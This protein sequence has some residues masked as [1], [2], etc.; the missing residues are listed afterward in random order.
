[1]YLYYF[2][3]PTGVKIIVKIFVFVSL[4]LAKLPRDDYTGP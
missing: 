1:M 3:T 2:I 4:Q